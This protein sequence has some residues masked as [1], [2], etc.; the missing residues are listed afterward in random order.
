MCP[1]ARCVPG[2]CSRLAGPPTVSTPALF[3]ERQGKTAGGLVNRHTSEAPPEAQPEA[4][5]SYIFNRHA[6]EV[7]D[8]VLQ[9]QHQAGPS[10]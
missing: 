5:S 2:A 1:P 7:G 8:A 10:L 4:T 6:Y 3:L 9:C